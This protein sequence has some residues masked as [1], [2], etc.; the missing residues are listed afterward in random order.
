[1]MKKQKQLPASPAQSTP[2]K[3]AGKQALQTYTT[4]EVKETILKMNTAGSLNP[5]L[6]LLANGLLSK[7]QHSPKERSKVDKEF[8]EQASKVIY[9][10][11]S[12]THVAMMEGFGE[13]LQCGAREICKQFIQDFDC[14][15]NAEKILAETATV[16]FMR[17]LDG[18]RRFNGCLTA[19]EELTPKLP[20]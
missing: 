20:G 17:Y 7:W 15:T 4:Q 10:F 3:Q 11:E 14:T 9:G 19:T 16:A 12:D 5:A 13:R 18:S 1:M 8:Q 2:D 6:K